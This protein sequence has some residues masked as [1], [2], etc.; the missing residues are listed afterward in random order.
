SNTFGCNNL[1]HT[2][3]RHETRRARNDTRHTPR[4]L[5]SRAM[6]FRAWAKPHHG[7]FV[8]E[9]VEHLGGAL[10]DFAVAAPHDW[11]RLYRHRLAPQYALAQRNANAPVETTLPMRTHSPP[12]GTLVTVPN[13][14]L[15]S[16]TSSS[17]I[18]SRAN[19]LKL[20]KY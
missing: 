15:P 18:S 8:T 17:L 4:Q 11:Q 19:S 20:A 14:P 6:G 16:V 1:L 13:A 7:A 5:K 9:V 10:A 12:K 2:H 3:T